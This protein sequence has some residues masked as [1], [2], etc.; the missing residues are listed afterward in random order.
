MYGFVPINTNQPQTMV[1][2]L[3]ASIAEA[4]D[5][6]KYLESREKKPEPFWKTK[7]TLLDSW[8]LIILFGLI[9]AAPIVYLLR[10]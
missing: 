9:T 10:G 5:L 8:M 3:K 7:M 1:A 2:A 6:K 4:E